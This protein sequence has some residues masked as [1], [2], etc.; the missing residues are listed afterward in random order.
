MPI[1]RFFVHEL[2]IRRWPTR[3]DRY[4]NT[5]RNLDGTPDETVVLGWVGPSQTVEVLT[6]GRSEQRVQRPC[7][8]P[9]DTDLLAGDQIVR[10]GT[11]YEIDGIPDVVPTPDGPH[12][13]HARLLAVSG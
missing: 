13:V 8:L 12:H 11:A 6:G 9:V 1:E 4:N 10:D 5:V 7:R 3:V 2:T